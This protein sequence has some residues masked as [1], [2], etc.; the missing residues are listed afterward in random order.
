MEV[1]ATGFQLCPADSCAPGQRRF[2][3]PPREVADMALALAR[4]AGIDVGGFEF[5]SGGGTKQWLCYDVNALSNFAP[6]AAGHLGFD[7][8]ARLAAYL[9]RRLDVPVR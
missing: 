5:L 6:E 3:D 1:A 2:V 8:V 7:P 9:R 4:H